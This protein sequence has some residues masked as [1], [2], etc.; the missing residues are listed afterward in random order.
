MA[1]WI[2]RKFA[3]QG[4]LLGADYSDGWWGPESTNM[5]LNHLVI[6]LVIWATVSVVVGLWLGAIMKH[7]AASDAQA[8]PA[9]RE[10]RLNKSAA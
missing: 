3:I 10:M 6:G 5:T 9:I 8:T 2:R 4:L 1:A 7:C